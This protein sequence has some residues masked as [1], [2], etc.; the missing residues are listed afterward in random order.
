MFT[1]TANTVLFDIQLPDA[2]CQSLKWCGNLR[3]DHLGSS[4]CM[5][6]FIS[7]QKSRKSDKWSSIIPV[8]LKWSSHRVT[9][10]AA[11]TFI[12]SAVKCACRCK[13]EVI[14]RR[15][16]G[17]GRACRCLLIRR[18]RPVGQQPALWIPSGTSID[19]ADAQPR[20]A[21]GQFRSEVTE[22]E[23]N[24]LSLAHTLLGFR[25]SPAGLG[26]LTEQCDQLGWASSTN[27]P[28]H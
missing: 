9:Y 1:Q 13:S 11:D 15:G 8:V 25:P 21:A 12:D 28:L 2:V 4:A 22:T 16:S 17:G 23:T 24:S 14:I 10:G 7:P 6:I 5:G 27:T 19:C 18:T 26:L 20:C 3:S